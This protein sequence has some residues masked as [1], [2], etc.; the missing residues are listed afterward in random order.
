[1]SEKGKIIIQKSKKGFCGRIEISGK[2]MPV[3]SFYELKD[4][5]LNGKECEIEREKGQIKKIAINGEELPKRIKSTQRQFSNKFDTR[6]SNKQEKNTESFI[7]DSLDISRAKLP[8][9]TMDILMGTKDIDNFT[10]KLNKAARFEGDKFEFFKTDKTGIKYRIKADFPKDMVRETANK[11]YSSIEKLN[12]KLS[13]ALILKPDWRLVIGLGNESVYEASMT[14]HH[15]YGIPYIPGQAV[16]GVVRNY[17]ITERFECSEGQALQD[18]CFRAI[19]GGQKC[20]G[21][22]IFFDAFPLEP[23]NI[24]PDV[25]NVHYPDYY[26]DN[27]LP[28]D[29]QNP[30]P[31]F[32]LT[33]KETQFKFVIGIK[34]KNDNVITEGIFEG[35]YVLETAFEYLRKGLSEHGIGAKTAVGYGYMNE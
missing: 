32:F 11:Y 8:Q 19:F 30:K 22:V 13:E 1:M 26:S 10:L 27:K 12:L 14:L 18:E 2:I 7:P 29:Y 28:A 33:V 6:K 24:E 25:M 20:K 31:I 35:R 23:P 21:K 9:D 5:S 15:I 3:P 4:D 34:E 17:I 16:K